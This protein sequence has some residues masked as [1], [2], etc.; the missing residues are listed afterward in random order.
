MASYT[1]A[2][3]AHFMLGSVGR[4]LRQRRPS[5]EWHRTVASHVAGLCSSLAVCSFHLK[6]RGSRTRDLLSSTSPACSRGEFDR[7][8]LDKKSGIEED[9]LVAKYGSTYQ[10]YR[11]KVSKFIPWIY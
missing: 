5:L 9:L 11:G 1:L 4:Y 7:V 2:V 10:E 8:L 6:R 3:S